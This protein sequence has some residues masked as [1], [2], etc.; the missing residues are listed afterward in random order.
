MLPQA[1]STYRLGRAAARASQRA[2][3]GSYFTS[4]QGQPSGLSQRE[5][6]EALL[7]RMTKKALVGTAS[8]I[9]MVGNVLDLPGSSVRDVF[10]GQNPFDQWLPWNWTNANNRATGEDLLKQVGAISKQDQSGFL[11]N[12]PRFTAGVGLEI[13]MDPLTYMT[14]GASSLVKGAGTAARKTNL[15][16]NAVFAA[17]K[18]FGKKAGSI[19]KR[20]ARMLV[21]PEDLVKYT[22]IDDAAEAGAAADFKRSQ[23]LRAGLKPEQFNDIIG[24]G[25]ASFQVPFTNATWSPFM[26]GGQPHKWA[27]K[28]AKGL[29]TAGAAIAN[30]PGIKHGAQLFDKGARMAN[31]ALGRAT[32]REAHRADMT[33]K[34]QARKRS[35]EDIVGME[36]TGLLKTV[37]DGGKFTKEQVLE[38]VSAMKS[39]SEDAWRDRRFRYE[40]GDVEDAAPDIVE[41]APDPLNGG[42]MKRLGVWD[43]TTEGKAIQQFFDPDDAYKLRP[44]F[45]AI[46]ETG[47]LEILDSNKQQT[48]RLLQREI[49]EGSGVT[50]L[51]DL[52]NTYLPR[53]KQSL[54]EEY[55]TNDPRSMLDTM[56]PHAIGRKDFGMRW[57]NATAQIDQMSMDTH[58]AKSRDYAGVFDKD[59]TPELRNAWEDQDVVREQFFKDFAHVIVGEKGLAPGVT[60]EKA[61]NNKQLRDKLNDL[62]TFVTARNRDDVINKVSA[63]KSNPV[64]SVLKRAEAA[65]R[66][67]VNMR[68]TK[69]MMRLAARRLPRSAVDAPHRTRAHVE[70]TGAF[71]GQVNPDLYM[72]DGYAE[73]WGKKHGRDPDEWFKDVTFKNYKEG[74]DTPQ[75]IAQA[76]GEG[77]ILW[78][79]K[80]VDD[81]G[82]WY[83]QLDRA[84]TDQHFPKR[85]MDQKEMTKFFKHYDVTD[86]EIADLSLDT[87]FADRKSV[88]QQN[89]IDW[90]SEHRMNLEETIISDTG[91]RARTQEDLLD[92]GFDITKRTTKGESDTWHVRTSNKSELVRKRKEAEQKLTGLRDSEYYKNNYNKAQSARAAQ[93][94][95]IEH[96]AAQLGELY[97]TEYDIGDVYRAWGDTRSANAAQSG[98]ALAAEAAKHANPQYRALESLHM[99]LAS[100]RENPKP[101]KPADFEEVENAILQANQDTGGKWADEFGLGDGQ[102]VPDYILKQLRTPGGESDMY[103]TLLIKKDQLDGYH[104]DP[105]FDQTIK[106]ERELNETIT[107]TRQEILDRQRDLFPGG[108]DSISG[109]SLEEVL[110]KA[111]PIVDANMTKR[112]ETE[113]LHSALGGTNYREIEMRTPMDGSGNQDTVAKFSLTDRVGDNGEKILQVD[114]FASPV[115]AAGK[116]TGYQNRAEGIQKLKGKRKQAA[117]IDANIKERTAA[118]ERTAKSIDTRAQK[119]T[120]ALKQAGNVY[121]E[122]LETYNLGPRNTRGKRRVFTPTSV[123]EMRLI[124]TVGNDADMVEGVMSKMDL[125]QTL[126]KSDD[127]FDNDVIELARNMYLD[128]QPNL[129]RERIFEELTEATISD[130]AIK[131]L[132]DQGGIATETIVEQHRALQKAKD[133]AGVFK[134][135]N[136][137]IKSGKPIPEEAIAKVTPGEPL[138]QAK[139]YIKKYN[140]ELEEK[141]LW[142]TNREDILA[143]VEQTLDAPFKRS[144]HRRA[145]KRAIQEATNNGYDKIVFNTGD[146]AGRRAMKAGEAI[147][148]AEATKLYDKQL[149]AFINE[150]GKEYGVE[151]RRVVDDTHTER[152]RIAG[153]EDEK[154]AAIARAN[155]LGNTPD[156]IELLRHADEQTEAMKKSSKRINQLENQLKAIE[157]EELLALDRSIATADRKAAA[158][159]LLAQ[160]RAELT[161]TIPEQVSLEMSQ[162]RLEAKIE[163]A[164]GDGV[165]EAVAK[166]MAKIDS[167]AGDSEPLLSSVKNLLSGGVATPAS[168]E[169]AAKLSSQLDEVRKLAKASAPVTGKEIRTKFNLIREIDKAQWKLARR[170]KKVLDKEIARLK[171]VD[172]EELGKPVHYDLNAPPMKP[173]ITAPEKVARHHNRV[174]QAEF[175]RAKLAT[176]MNELKESLIRVEKADPYGPA[177]RKVES[178]LNKIASVKARIARRKATPAAKHLISAGNKKDIKRLGQLTDEL[179]LLRKEAYTDLKRPDVA[180]MSTKGFVRS[181]TA[182]TLNEFNRTGRKLAQI[183]TAR[184]PLEQA[185]EVGRVAALDPLQKELSTPSAHF[186]DQTR[187]NIA[188]R[189]ANLT[190]RLSLEKLKLKNEST[191][192][193]AQRISDSPAMRDTVRQLKQQ[194]TQIDDKIA[195]MLAVSGWRGTVVG[196]SWSE[197][198]GEIAPRSLAEHVASGHNL[199]EFRGAFKSAEDIDKAIQA[200]NKALKEALQGKNATDLDKQWNE[201]QK[202]DIERRE[203]I[204]AG[205]S[206]EDVLHLD[207]EVKRLSQG[208][209]MLNK[210]MPSR[211]EMDITPKMSDDL[212]QEKMRMLYKGGKD[213]AT[214]AYM[215]NKQTGK[216]M[217][218]AFKGADVATFWH[219][220]AHM[221]RQGLQDLNPEAY[222]KATKHMDSL[223]LKPK[224]NGS[225]TRE[226][227]EKFAEEFEIFAKSKGKKV[228]S[229]G[230]RGMLEAA[231]D[232]VV[233]TYRSMT[234]QGQKV[235]LSEGLNEVFAEML[236]PYLRPGGTN[237]T[238]VLTEA[239]FGH[240][241]AMTAMFRSMGDVGLEVQE[242]LIDRAMKTISEANSKGRVPR[243]NGRGLNPENLLEAKKKYIAKHG[244]QFSVETVEPADVLAQFDIPQD[245]ADD[246]VRYAAKMTDPSRDNIALASYDMFTNWF[247]THVT[248]T[249]PAFHARNA[250]SG[251]MQNNLNGVYD[252]R[253]KN[254]A[255]RY[256]QHY[257]DMKRLMYGDNVEGALDIPLFKGEGFSEEQ[258]TN[259]LKKLMFSWGLLD[260][261]AQYNDLV[262]SI[263]DQFADWMPGQRKVNNWREWVGGRA[264][265]SRNAGSFERDQL[266]RMRASGQD[267]LLPRYG[268][269]VGD[270]VES[271]H[272]GGGFIALLRQGYSPAAAAR[273]VKELQ[274]D[275]SNL[276]S[277]EK[278][279]MRRAMPFYSFTRQ[280]TEMMTK[281][282]LQRPGGP[283]AQSIRAGNRAGSRDD[284]LAPDYV[285]QGVSIPL[286]KLPDGSQRYIA[287]FGLM[288]E[289]PLQ[290]LQPTVQGAI[291][292]GLS[293]M[294]PLPKGI[295]ELG[296]D[297]SLFQ[298]G[299][300]G[301]RALSDQDP[302]VGRAI[303]NTL[304]T[305]QLAMQGDPR[306][307]M[308][309]DDERI[310]PVRL[311]KTFESLSSNWNPFSR[312]VSTWRQ[313][314][315]PRKGPLTKAIATMTG[316]RVVDVSPASQ[317]AMLRELAQ[318]AMEDWGGRV[319]ALPYTPKHLLEAMNPEE[320]R[321]AEDYAAL[322]R[323]LAR[324]SRSRKIEGEKKKKETTKSMISFSMP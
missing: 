11:N 208:E 46:R 55:R 283:M 20:E 190:E 224:P 252:P 289:S 13:L 7:K 156:G 15:L 110:A 37:D 222:A 262:G 266:G 247:K 26:S 285:K 280:M 61:L 210:A 239:N 99:K 96:T 172:V 51:T 167:R 94:K 8:G 204:K 157:E 147:D 299:P 95:N 17:E 70:A 188:R 199:K 74:A 203:A 136:K 69:E 160:R 194:R 254:P 173:T 140:D 292:Q 276:T 152:M 40:W 159:T 242:E 145:M 223:G 316:V 293:Q 230:L 193:E 251:W 261:P 1:T 250:F 166:Y 237:M 14:L 5:E 146:T 90:V 305:G 238:K 133:R 219:E 281:E 16:D 12:A 171:K 102:A 60:I 263:G 33:A 50:E 284:A 232:W 82:K 118:L 275:Y 19:G 49:D 125:A 294:N 54:K 216:H 323:L 287:G 288:H 134:G 153:L 236:G 226:M 34:A 30:A 129:M 92:A 126:I 39:Y 197:V 168:A 89:V 268:R 278:T 56:D 175:L 58:P 206:A 312:Y 310:P 121:R 308:G 23:L 311:G 220:S 63:F 303:T 85:S 97:G 122:T 149:P 117:A 317:D 44:E 119:E 231:K 170:Q 321:E 259:E 264:K 234:G 182:K 27:L 32:G 286:G 68:H 307:I 65:E 64:E 257:T 100:M 42:A 71:G 207:N 113:A 21:T 3:S 178:V 76:F 270:S 214:G 62:F 164:K 131:Y 31:T 28:Y 181:E 142:E 233:S 235:E 279:F 139:Q 309:G 104:K 138:E 38:H 116:K 227:D 189:K 169:R 59:A 296:L 105:R 161:S 114:G 127:P 256:T 73:M 77:N 158:D 302:L 245:V 29:D 130:E 291:Y 151:A 36:K 244:E 57:E 301:G 290:L 87:L 67:I 271:L 205:K 306:A 215:F 186:I 148:I 137:V 91:F 41:W 265:A 98:D 9:G 43:E 202:L 52:L 269:A 6:D 273:R 320:K 277:F 135:L 93:D 162:T 187:K 243:F 228:R 24:R 249:M 112:P 300:Q 209:G 324:M 282:L 195:R 47:V 155:E 258:A 132:N 150:F 253:F 213:D 163:K 45:D 211:W 314:M 78:Q 141:Q 177:Q 260:S 143:G 10:A 48:K 304:R 217:L 198:A 176:K 272:R 106:L 192:L 111:R 184:G 313:G 35:Y 319:M 107:S 72:L 322:M 88:T 165:T 103:S 101:W 267:M 128:T 80:T 144:W 212:A 225:W 196:K 124:E 274:L 297:E 4:T 81:P 295:L 255:Q 75:S 109:N 183:A 298:A 218:M 123:N 248:A 191:L 221:F 108:T 185:L 66:S 201:L 179:R 154:A 318:G 120:A 79:G 246:L 180:T 200:Q 84:L 22:N 115:H 2:D 229:E 86:E 25:P 174:A 241:N 18:K 83:S 53:I 240:S 315:D